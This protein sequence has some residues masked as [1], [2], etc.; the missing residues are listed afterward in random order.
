MQYICLKFF[1]GIIAESIYID[2]LKFLEG[3]KYAFLICC[4][5]V[6][7]NIEWL[8]LK[9]WKCPCNDIFPFILYSIASIFIKVIGTMIY[10]CNFCFKK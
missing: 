3:L 2:I 8:L 4:D 5:L 1:I 10:W 9:C 6:A 7:F